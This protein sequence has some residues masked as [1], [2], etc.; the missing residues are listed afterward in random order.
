[1]RKV[2]ALAAVLL[3]MSAT[4]EGSGGALVAIT[5]TI[6]PQVVIPSD[7]TAARWCV[8]AGTSA[9]IAVLLIFAAI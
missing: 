7:E 2:A 8:F 6:W 9:L 3:L 5:T 1:M 4:A